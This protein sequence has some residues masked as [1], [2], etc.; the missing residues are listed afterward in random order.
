MILLY[1]FAVY[2]FLVY[3]HALYVSVMGYKRRRD[4]VGLNVV[5]R[6]NV[7]CLL[8]PVAYVWDLGM[9]LLVCIATLRYPQ[10]WR[11]LLLTGMLRRFINTEEGWRF[12]FAVWVCR[13]L[14]NPYDE[15][16]CG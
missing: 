1:I 6:V 3:G 11:E 4:T 13:D 14:L 9:C 8:M 10:A 2:A 12:E 5:E 16:H 7:Y 15:R